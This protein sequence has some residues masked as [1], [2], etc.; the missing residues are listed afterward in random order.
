LTVN[1]D[2]DV[3]KEIRVV[4]PS[5]NVAY[6]RDKIKTRKCDKDSLNPSAGPDSVRISFG[7]NPIEGWVWEN[8]AEFS[9]RNGQEYGFEKDNIAAAR[10][11]TANGNALLDNLILFAPD[12]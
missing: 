8:G 7:R 9:E 12:K 3:K 4:W 10:A 1:I 5:N 2:G 6:C 11:R